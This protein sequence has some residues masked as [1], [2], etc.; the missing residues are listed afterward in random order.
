[1]GIYYFRPSSGST[2]SGGSYTLPDDITVDNIL[3][4]ENSTVQGMSIIGVNDITPELFRNN[5]LIITERG[6]DLTELALGFSNPEIHTAFGVG[7]EN[8]F[9]GLME[10]TSLPWDPTVS[11]VM[12]LSF[13]HLAEDPSYSF[14]FEDRKSVV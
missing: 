5:S 8:N 9:Y 13:G 1:M 11:G 12:L 3:V 4:R 2:I 14:L 7:N 6:L 10:T